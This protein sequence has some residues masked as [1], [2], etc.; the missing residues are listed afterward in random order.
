MF[1]NIVPDRGGRA[2]KPLKVPSS[3]IH[4]NNVE[5]LVQYP[6]LI[7]VP[8]GLSDKLTLNKAA[9]YIAGAGR[10]MI[11][12]DTVVFD[13]GS[14]SIRI[15]GILASHGMNARG[16]VGL[17]LIDMIRVVLSDNNT[18]LELFII[19]SFSWKG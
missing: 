2:A 18:I 7:G 13:A 12:S 6:E 10:V 17:I 9:S 5:V 4:I 1:H 15:I 11:Q 19:V 8:G 16:N 3:S 14:P